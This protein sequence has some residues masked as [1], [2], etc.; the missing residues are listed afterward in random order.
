MG[1]FAGIVREDLADEV[2][3]LWRSPKIAEFA[4]LSE[5]LIDLDTA[6]RRGGA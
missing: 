1:E 4:A 5:C 3:E 2:F 6:M